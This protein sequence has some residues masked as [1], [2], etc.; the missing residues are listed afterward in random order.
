MSLMDPRLPRIYI[1]TSMADT[2]APGKAVPVK[3][4]G[5]LQAALDSATCGETLKLEAGATFNGRIKLPKKPVTMLLD[6]RADERPGRKLA[7]RRNAAYTLLCRG[8]LTPGRPDF[9][10]NA[11]RNVMAKITFAIKSGIG[12]ILFR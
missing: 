6:H 12:P 1:K 3:G 2:P 11:T 4:G 9:H 7:S 5:D 8:S 10:C